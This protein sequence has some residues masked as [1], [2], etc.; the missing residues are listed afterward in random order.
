MLEA[1]PAFAAHTLNGGAVG[2]G[3]VLV[4]KPLVCLAGLVAERAGASGVV[5]HGSC[6]LSQG[7]KGNVSQLGLY[8]KW[9]TD[10]FCKKVFHLICSPDG[11]QSFS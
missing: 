7:D 6:S 1:F 4:E 10:F 8:V 5:G 9:D 3:F 2:V 11:I